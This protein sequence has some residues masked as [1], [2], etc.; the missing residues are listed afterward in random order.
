M[1]QLHGE[2]SYRRP[3]T[4]EFCKQACTILN[5]VKERQSE[6]HCELMGEILLDVL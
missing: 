3:V 4:A 2:D 5:K 6:V 1:C